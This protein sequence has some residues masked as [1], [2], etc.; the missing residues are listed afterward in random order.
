MQVK[1]I[2]SIIYDPLPELPWLVWGKWNYS[3]ILC[4]PLDFWLLWRLSR[5][6][7][8]IFGLYVWFHANKLNLSIMCIPSGF[9]YREGL[10]DFSP[11]WCR[12]VCLLLHCGTAGCGC[13][14]HTMSGLLPGCAACPW[15]ARSLPV[16]AFKL[17]AV[18]LCLAQLSSRA[19]LN[20]ADD[21]LALTA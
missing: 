18:V 9:V 4:L 3:K 8:I 12:T 17:G 1:K 19:F 2:K 5:S 13:E 15:T 11:V 7:W 6:L 16:F 21:A 20:A 10:R 14:L